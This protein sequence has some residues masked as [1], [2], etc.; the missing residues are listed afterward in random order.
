MVLWLTV[1]GFIGVSE[2]GV[3][4]LAYGYL[5]HARDP[6]KVVKAVNI[7]EL[8]VIEPF[9]VGWLIYGNTFHFTKE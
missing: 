5:E 8:L 7:L 6:L 3:K 2:G 1:F 4:L 9:R